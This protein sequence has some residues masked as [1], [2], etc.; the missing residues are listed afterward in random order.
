MISSTEY[1]FV[2]KTHD[3][4][5]LVFFLEVLA[6]HV[7]GLSPPEGRTKT[8]MPK[9]SFRTPCLDSKHF[10]SSLHTPHCEFESRPVGA[11]SSRC[12]LHGAHTASYEE[13]EGVVAH[14]LNLIVTEHPTSLPAP[15]RKSPLAA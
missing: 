4:F 15:I 14:T 9:R 1:T 10:E 11:S 2:A 7:W 6:L 5:I 13:I 12:T 3:L 8:T